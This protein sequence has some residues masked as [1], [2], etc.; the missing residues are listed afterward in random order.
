MPNAGGSRSHAGA[1][2]LVPDAA[3]CMLYQMLVGIWS[4]VT[5]PDAATLAAH[6]G[7]QAGPALREAK[8]HSHRVKP[9]LEYGVVISSGLR[10][11]CSTRRAP[12]TSRR[13]SVMALLR[14]SPRR[15]RQQLPL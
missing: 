4:A 15:R 12:P 5:P 6:S 1:W 13:P 9:N 14:V 8:R 2:P 10:R 11:G 3:E 7:W